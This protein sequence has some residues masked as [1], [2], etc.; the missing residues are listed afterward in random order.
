[1]IAMKTDEK[2][3]EKDE[4][5]TSDEAWNHP[6]EESHRKWHEESCKEC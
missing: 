1:M 2:V 6:N 4:P 5:K 3:T